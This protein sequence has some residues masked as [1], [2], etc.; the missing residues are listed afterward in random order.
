MTIPTQVAQVVNPF[1]G[2]FGNGEMQIIPVSGTFNVP[3][4]V[5][6]VRVR[7]WGAGGS[8][9]GPI[10]SGG[11]FA[12]RVIQLGSTT[13]V[14]VT[15]GSSATN[16]AGGTSSFGSYVS[17]TGGGGSGTSG[18]GTGVGGDINYLG[19][20][21]ATSSASGGGGGAA[22]LFGTGG[23]GAFNV[24]T[25]SGGSGGGGSSTTAGG[26]G[27]F[28]T[29]ASQLSSQGSPVPPTSGMISPSIDFIGTGGGGTSSGN[30]DGVNG[31]GGAG[32]SGVGGFPGGGG[33]SG[34]RG[35][36]IVEY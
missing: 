4:G 31:G 35:L 22:S 32:N 16:A 6:R 25:R 27:I 30:V 18:G 1:S 3:L 26:N 14:A 11:G 8:G 15:V 13:S 12:M 17:A 19:G 21:G 24:V 28:S 10:G 20:A 9:G 2:V 5:S 36:V 29:G 34:G 33:V 7:L 23:G